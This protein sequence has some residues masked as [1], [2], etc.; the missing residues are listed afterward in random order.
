MKGIAFALDPDGYWIEIVSRHPASIVTNKYT[1]AQTM[2]RVKDAQ[3]ALFFYRDLLGMTLIRESHFSD[4][5]LYFLAHISKE[6]V[7][8]VPKDPTSTEAYDYIRCMFGPIIELTHNH[9]TETDPTFKY[10]TIL[11]Y[12]WSPSSSYHHHHITTIIIDYHNLNHDAKV[13]LVDVYPSLCHQHP[14]L[15]FHSYRYYNGNDQDQDW[16]VRGFGHVGFLVDD[17]EAACVSLEEKGVLFKKKPSEGTMRG[18]AFAYD[19]DNYWYDKKWAEREG[20]G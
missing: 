5:S 2:F 8:N 18:L 17:L 20:G 9:G 11:V 10:D 7:V 15:L 1:F 13:I 16:Q 3:K 6:E 14:L 12:V 4:F 19:P